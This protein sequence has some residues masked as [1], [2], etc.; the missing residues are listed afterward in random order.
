MEMA[1]L[2]RLFYIDQGLT[3]IEQIQRKYAPVGA[4]ND[5]NNINRHWT[6]SV[7]SLYNQLRKENKHGR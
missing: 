1:R 5:L 6:S 4:D 7:T 2:L 3:T